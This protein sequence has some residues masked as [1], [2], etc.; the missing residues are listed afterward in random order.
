MTRRRNAPRPAPQPT[1]ETIGEVNPP[2]DARAPQDNDTADVLEAPDSLSPP[3]PGS[4]LAQAIEGAEPGS[5]VD[6]AGWHAGARGQEPDRAPPVD[7]NAL[8][9][10]VGPAILNSETSLRRLCGLLERYLGRVAT[11]LE[12]TAAMAEARELRREFGREPDS[13][14]LDAIV[15]GLDDRVT[16]LLSVQ[17]QVAGTPQEG[18][19]RDGGV[20]ASA[21]DG[22]SYADRIAGMAQDLE[23]EAD[24]DEIAREMTALAREMDG[25]L[26]DDAWGDD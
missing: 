9:W 18:T 1:P 6:P 8:A 17:E 20:A 7:L 3:R 14:R 4:E 11:A 23:D 15:A 2:D 10:D 24:P 12:R 13:K 22:V 21:D 16:A 5:P 26:P 25:L 19:E